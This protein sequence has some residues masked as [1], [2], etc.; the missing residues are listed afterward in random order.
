MSPENI[1]P[2]NTRISTDTP[3]K[4][5]AREIIVLVVL[6]IIVSL[7]LIFFYDRSSDNENVNPNYTD[8][9]ENIEIPGAFPI[10]LIT[11]DGIDLSSSSYIETQEPLKR[12]YQY[13]ARSLQNVKDLFDNA[14]SVVVKDGFTIETQD[15]ITGSFV[16]T[17]GAEG[18]MYSVYD[19]GQPQVMINII[20]QIVT[21]QN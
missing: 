3:Y 16:A 19:I 6:I 20:Y 14:L 11:G 8:R 9:T 10:E 15:E 12:E 13:T 1:Q 5:H 4:I 17:R 21:T 18:I 2:D 7:Y